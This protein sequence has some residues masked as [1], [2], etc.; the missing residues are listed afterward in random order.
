MKAANPNEVI[1]ALEVISQW[2]IPSEDAI[3]SA[4]RSQL[5]RSYATCPVWWP[6]LI[7]GKEYYIRGEQIITLEEYQFN[8]AIFVDGAVCEC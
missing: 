1:R 8:L 2:N 6:L 5:P 4:I 3:T 7:E